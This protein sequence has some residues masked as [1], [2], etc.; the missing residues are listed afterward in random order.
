L[1]HVSDGIGYF[2]FQ[3]VI[4]VISCVRHPKKLLLI[5]G[6]ANQLLLTCDHGKENLIFNKMTILESC[7]FYLDIAGG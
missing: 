7:I 3:S 6:V 5:I 4:S 1:Q 2:C